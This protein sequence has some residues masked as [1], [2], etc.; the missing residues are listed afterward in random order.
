MKLDKCE[1]PSEGTP[2]W[3]VNKYFSERNQP[4]VRALYLRNIETKIT[5]AYT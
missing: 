1:D 5:S 3:L 4:K 2:L